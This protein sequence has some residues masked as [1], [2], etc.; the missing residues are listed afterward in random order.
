MRPEPRGP[1]RHKQDLQGP[2]RM[3]SGGWAPCK[4][5]L[6]RMKT[7]GCRAAAA[8]VLSVQRRNGRRQRQRRS[9]PADHRV[10]HRCG[11]IGIRRVGWDRV[12]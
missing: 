12:E 3:A 2:G 6:P 10:A 4:K 8:V 11:V 1:E 5:I 9:D 7:T